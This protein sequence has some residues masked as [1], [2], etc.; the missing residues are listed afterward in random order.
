MA[1]FEVS[2]RYEKCSGHRPSF[3]A[4]CVSAS[5]LLRENNF[6]LL[7]RIMWSICLNQNPLHYEIYLRGH[8]R[9]RLLSGGH[10][11]IASGVKIISRFGTGID[12]IDLRGHSNPVLLSIMRLGLIQ[13]RLGIYHWTYLREHEKYPWQ[14]SWMQNGYWGESHGCE[15]QGKRIAWLATVI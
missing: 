5:K 10:A 13:M 12:N 2:V 15:L 9:K 3:S 14:L 11:I 8:R 7:L 6:I 4:R 1:F